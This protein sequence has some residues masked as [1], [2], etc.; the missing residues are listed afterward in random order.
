MHKLV[1]A[2]IVRVHLSSDDR[3]GGRPLYEA[4]VDQCRH[5]GIAGA[6]VLAG[7][8]GFGESAE[9]LRANIFGGVQPI[10]V[11]I[12]D[13]EENTNRLLPTLREM[14]PSGLIAVS[15]AMTMR[16]QKTI[17]K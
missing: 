3:L 11:T 8:Q 13:T 6:T 12:I 1:P 2:K 16:I 7:V 17:L 10:T 5:L 15:D 4:I 9:V 14:V